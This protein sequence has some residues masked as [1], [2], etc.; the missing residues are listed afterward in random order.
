MQNAN[1]IIPRVW[2]GNRFAAVNE[3]W[4]A[5]KNITVV[6]N[7]TKDLPY[8]PSIKRR[9][10]IPV[11]DNLEADEIN[12]MT[13]WSPEIA[14]KILRE[15]NTGRNILIH[16]A[17]GMQRSAA[18]LTIFLITLTGESAPVLMSHIRRKRP[19]A[20]VPQANFRKSIEYYDKLYHNDIAP[21]VKTSYTM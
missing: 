5:E 2:L 17:A 13:K 12:N 1:E 14:Y 9:Y 10:R 19:I 11:H 18:A 3:E 4:L 16:C 15:Y 6:F 20:F 7:C 21:H 8:S